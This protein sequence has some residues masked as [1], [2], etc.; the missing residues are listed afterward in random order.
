MKKC[1][2]KRNNA[3]HNDITRDDVVLIKQSKLIKISVPY[4]P[5]PMLVQKNK[6]TMMTV[7]R[8]DGSTITRNASQ[9]KRFPPTAKPAR[10]HIDETIDKEINKEVVIEAQVS[11]NIPLVTSVP[12]L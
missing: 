7:A 5:K 8:P 12:T 9:F 1:T 4:L 11:P 6:G 10:E 3:N 2:D